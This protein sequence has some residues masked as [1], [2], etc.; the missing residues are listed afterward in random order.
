M[1]SDEDDTTSVKKEKVKLPTFDFYRIGFDITKIIASLSQ[2]DYNVFEGQLDVHYKANLFLDLEFGHGNSKVNNQ[3]LSYKSSNT[4]IRVGIDK[5]FF[6]S[7][8]KGDFD[9][10][11]VGVRY[12]LSTVT[13]GDA[14]Y[15]VYDQIW[16]NRTGTIPSSKFLAHWLELNAGFRMELV[17]RIFV[18]WNMRFKTLVNASKFELLPPSYLAGYGR[19]EKRTAFGYNFYV[20]YGFGK[21]K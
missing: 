19:G 5:T 1:Q 9:N 16:G 10:A 21:R 3:Y 7:E 12:G 4:F 20:L 18:G 11:F 15:Y 6:G 14:T 8:F 13:R 2:S 17:K